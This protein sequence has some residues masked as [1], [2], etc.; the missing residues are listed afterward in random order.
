MAVLSTLTRE[1]FVAWIGGKAPLAP[2][3]GDITDR[4]NLKAGEVV[5]V[6]K[7][8]PS[9]DDYVET[10]RP[11]IGVRPND[12]KEFMAFTTT[13]FANYHPF[14]AFFRVVPLD[15]LYN[16]LDEQAHPLDR[17]PPHHLVGA[18]IAEA[19]SQIGDRVRSP[20]D[21]S[22]QSCLA[23]CS[24][25]ALAL[26]SAGFESEYLIPMFNTW[27]STRERLN[28]ER[29]RL[30]LEHISEF[31][32]IIS[33][34]YGRNTV[35]SRLPSGAALTISRFITEVT[36]T[37]EDFELE[38]WDTLTTGLPNTRR[39]L[40]SMREAREDRVRALDDLIPEVLSTDRIDRR[41]R[42]VAAGY[43]ASRIAGGSLRYLSLL[44]PL[45]TALPLAPM[46]FGL[47]AS[48]RKD[49]DALT[50]GDCL[51]RRIVRQL[52]STS[53]IF[54]LPD[55]DISAEELEALSPE[56]RSDLK[57][58]TEHQG[59]ISVEVFPTITA[60]FRLPK[61][62][63]R[64]AD[65]PPLPSTSPLPPKP[66]QEIQYLLERLTRRINDLQRPAQQNLFGEDLRRSRVPKREK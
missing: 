50:V 30:S 20:S 1:Q 14:S 51:G 4:R 62:V 47:F 48:L 55:A 7:Q 66:L 64:E 16:H 23:T 65:T 9:V 34:V 2:G 33:G 29:L 45:E 41:I 52:E 37:S 28:D 36:H 19:R 6:W 54:A 13:F 57:F 46:W 11:I 17:L 38:T 26:L 8:P 42:E 27:M 32:E 61:D 49:T 35:R 31:W 53:D 18:V 25:P 43:L 44:R 56:P 5:L 60:T 10:T 3:V 58:R 40:S 59:S 63:R 22:I 15:F 39:A 24:Y 21:L 12:L